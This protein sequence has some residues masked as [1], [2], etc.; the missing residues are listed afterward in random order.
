MAKIIDVDQVEELPGIRF[1]GTDYVIDP[2]VAE[3]FEAEEILRNPEKARD[4]KAQMRVIQIM[5][6]DLDVSVIRKS[7]IAPIMKAI[8]DALSKNAFSPAATQSG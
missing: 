7:E 1:H 5:V 6:P 2:S 3:M 4:L 8:F